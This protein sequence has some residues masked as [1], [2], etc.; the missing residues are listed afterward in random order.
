M[1]YI[2][3]KLIFVFSSQFFTINHNTSRW[4]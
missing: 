4:T 3:E 1:E 2:E